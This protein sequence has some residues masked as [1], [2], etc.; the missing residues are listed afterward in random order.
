MDGRIAVDRAYQVFIGGR[1][2]EGGDGVF[3]VI[4]PATGQTLA[5][6]GRASENDVDLAVGVAHAEFESGSWAR[7]SASERGRRLLAAASLMQDRAEDFAQLEARN[8][9]MPIGD[10]RGEVDAAIRTLEYY[11][12][13]ANKLMGEV[14]PVSSPGLGVVRREP[15]GV[16]ALIVPWNFPLLIATWKIAPALA[17]GNPVIL[18]PASYTPLTALMLGAL[19]IEAGV[20]ETCVSVLPGPGAT[21]GKRLVADPRVSKISFTGESATGSDILRRTADN[22]T[23]VSLELG[24][25]SACIVFGDSDLE[26]AIPSTITAVYGN[27]G[28]DCCA[29]SRVLVERNVY[30]RFLADFSQ[31]A[32]AIRMGDP[33]D[34][35]TEMGPLISDSHRQRVALY[36]GVGTDAGAKVSVG[37]HKPVGAALQAGFYFEPT[38]L[39]DVD[40]SMR[41]AREEIFGPIACLIPFQDE[42]DAIR[43]ANDSDYGLS[44][45]I[46]TRDMGTA[47]RV[48]AAVRTGVLSVN[49]NS[50][51]YLEAPLGGFKRSGLGRELGMHA[52]HTYTEVKSVY[53]AS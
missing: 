40:N 28:Q 5:Q 52:M 38:V 43:I 45:S 16:T 34:D 41:V 9:G 13:A 10:A 53:F 21:V 35:A 25:K 2:R 26:R 51:V 19:L 1:C 48:S 49:S 3:S 11:A 42:A 30:D 29:R 20:P 36:V 7:T 18:K 15:V 50:S 22:V 33:L 44:G 37:G 12:G 32:E 14:T 27:A 31:Q 17:C 24:G 47:L 8:V 6:V 23:R 46:W 4:E 39:M